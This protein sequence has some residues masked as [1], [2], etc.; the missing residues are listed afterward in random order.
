MPDCYTLTL[1][2]ECDLRS[3][4]SVQ[5]QLAAALATAGT[6]A[7]DASSVARADVT[8]VQLVVAAAGTA[9]RSGRT[10]RLAGLSEPARAAFERAGVSLSDLSPGLP[11]H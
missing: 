5:A 11:G 8:F 3:A 7:V 6:I 4:A 9:R 1:P 10:F 2:D